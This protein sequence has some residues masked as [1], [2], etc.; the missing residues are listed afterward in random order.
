MKRDVNLNLI[1]RYLADECTGEER[2]YVRRWMEADPQNRQAM[3]T[4]R[5]I[6]E[7]QPRKELESDIRLAWEKLE[8]QLGQATKTSPEAGKHTQKKRSYRQLSS[9]S[10]ASI[11]L[12][13]AAAI[14]VAFLLSLFFIDFENSESGKKTEVVMREVVTK[15]GNQ[16]Q[17][18]FSD[19]TRV[20][21]N[22][23]SRI[24]FP[25]RFDTDVRE[26]YLEGEAYFEVNHK[27]G[28]AFIVRTRD[29]DVKV[30]GTKFNVKAWSEDKK[31]EIA[32][33]QGSVSVQSASSGTPNKDSVKDGNSE[34]VLTE[35]QMSLVRQG[36]APTPPQTVNMENYLTWLRGDFVFD[37][38]PF[39]KV[40]REWERRFDVNFIVRDSSLL[41]VAFSGEFRNEPLNEMLRLAS[42]SLKFEHYRENRNIVINSS[43]SE[44]SE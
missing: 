7:V 18:T 34:V 43:A 31:V 10:Y 25:E 19:G 39:S 3:E 5:K 37:Q 26:V 6:W 21:L 32:V 38:V 22:A 4:L 41:Q 44:R 23:V 40:L 8:K 24:R 12:R 30:L 17:L 15:R 28:V 1:H 11:W 29:A 42:E 2:Q 13:V 27:P 20:V 16:A 36:L 33:A 35:G 9:S 14:A